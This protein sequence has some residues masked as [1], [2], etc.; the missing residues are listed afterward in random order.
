[1]TIDTLTIK[2]FRNYAA[3]AVKFSPGLN[4]LAGAN[5]QGKTNLLEAAYLCCVGRS[6]RTAKDKELIRWGREQGRVSVEV[7]K[8]DGKTTVEARLSRNENKRIAINSLPISRIGELMGAVNCVFF[9]PDELKIVKESPTD[10]RRFLDTDIC[11]MSKTYFY[12]LNRYNKILTQRNRLLKDGDSGAL[13]STLPVWDEQ[14]AAAGAG[15]IVTRRK[16]IDKLKP[17][18]KREH[19]FLTGGAEEIDLEY[20][21]IGGAGA[22]MGASGGAG[23]SMD[24]AA[25]KTAFLKALSDNRKRDIK[26]GFTGEGPH[27]DDFAVRLSGVDLRAFGSQ[28]QQRTAA[29]SLKL[30]ELE[31]FAGEIGEYPVLL[32][33]DVLSE[34][35]LSRQKQLLDRAQKV[36]TIMTC[37]HMDAPPEGAAV[38]RVEGGTVREWGIES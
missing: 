33:D 26:Y 18:V 10:R 36:Q 11:Q 12:L 19:L 3:Q 8:R 13:N 2:D 16:F 29:L 9:S 37:T 4:V 23:A 21:G 20:E 27:K 6:P 31:I 25:A 30:A 5:A 7:Q 24:V 32:L 28:G 15:I 1:M 34:L 14:L 35:D 17:L 38:W 22:G